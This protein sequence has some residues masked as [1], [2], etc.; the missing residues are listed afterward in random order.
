MWCNPRLT[1]KAGVLSDDKQHVVGK[2]MAY[3]RIL[4]LKN[5]FQEF[6]LA[7]LGEGLSLAW[8]GTISHAGLVRDEKVA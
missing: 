3:V 8:T 4:T 5:I 7:V 1:P 6:R 2:N